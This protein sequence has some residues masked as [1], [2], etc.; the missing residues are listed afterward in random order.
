MRTF[1]QS[2]RT[3][4]NIVARIALVSYRPTLAP[5]GTEATKFRRIPNPTAWLFSG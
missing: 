2:L 3:F 5:D 1:T 4:R